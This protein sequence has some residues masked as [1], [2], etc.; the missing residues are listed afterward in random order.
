MNIEKNNKLHMYLTVR[1]LLRSNRAIL[2]KLP[3]AAEF[4]SAL[5]AVIMD[6]QT[7]NALKEAGT[8]EKK[9][10]RID[11]KNAL[12]TAIVE[13]SGKLKAYASYKEDG[14]MLEFCKKTERMLK[15]MYDMDLVQ[16]AK[17]LYEKINVAKT[18]LVKYQLSEE[19]QE[20]L[21]QLITSF[22][23][24]SPEFSK[25]KSDYDQTKVS[26][27]ESYAKADAI[28]GKLDNELEIIK[29]SD[30]A[31][32]NQ[33]KE[34][35]RVVLNYDTNMV[36][37]H[38]LDAETGNGIPNA[39]VSLKLN[40]SMNEPIVKSSAEKGG[41]Q[42]KSITPGIYTVTVTKI[43]CKIQ[44]IPLTINGDDQVVFEVKMVKG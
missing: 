44:T 25:A 19:S 24:I 31:F 8:K 4:L 20:R 2:A 39:T 29:V 32:F 15:A 14:V 6:I 17:T 42:I 33:Y 28:M 38:I 41:L 12:I 3:N 26:V 37:G 34:L 18:E 16:H 36:V 23:A 30:S 7:Y 21:L 13:D 40:D 9:Q 5:D 35:R 1:V 22:E 11:A 43:G 27:D 10:Q